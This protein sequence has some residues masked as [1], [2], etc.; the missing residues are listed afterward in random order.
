MGTLELLGYFTLVVIYPITCTITNRLFFERSGPMPMLLAVDPGE[1]INK[2]SIGVCIFSLEGD[3]EIVFME[4]MTFT[5]FDK[6]LLTEAP[7]KNITQI[8]YEIYMIRREFAMRHVGSEVK[9][10]G[11]IGL[12]RAFA[13]RHDIPVA[14]QFSKI[15]PVTAKHFEVTWPIPDHDF[16]HH[17][18]A[19]L[20]GLHWL[21]Q[22]GLV[23][24]PLQ[25]RMAQQDDV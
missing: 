20:H 22:N 2:P 25:K 7:K 3:C 13:A 9:T 24:T 12:I 10:A 18:S 16:S 6:W 23:K 19:M 11:T 14:K 1:G 5:D 15:L 8:V 17:I 4:Q 21:E